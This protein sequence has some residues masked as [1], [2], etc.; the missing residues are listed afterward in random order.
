RR[1]RS[2]LAELLLGGEG[3]VWSRRY[4]RAAP[5]QVCSE[6]AEVA[7]RLRVARVVVGHSVQRGGRVSSR[8]GGQLVMADVG[9]SRAI[10]GEMAVLECT[11]GQ[12]RVLYGDGQSERL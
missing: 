10:A 11:A 4:E 3:A 1:Y 7:A 5:Q 6:V 2:A 8:C 9:I 12:M